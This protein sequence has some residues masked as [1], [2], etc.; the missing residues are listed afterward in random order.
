MCLCWVSILKGTHVFEQC[1]VGCES[2]SGHPKNPCW[3]EIG[4]HA[5]NLLIT[6]MNAI[7]HMTVGTCIIIQWLKKSSLRQWIEHTYELQNLWESEYMHNND[8][9]II[10]QWLCISYNPTYK[11]GGRKEDNVHLRSTYH[12]SNVK[13]TPRTSGWGDFWAS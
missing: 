1:M 3:N 4:L 7:I 8:L 6:I 10:S 2:R 11:R 12:T 5:E 9:L 13:P